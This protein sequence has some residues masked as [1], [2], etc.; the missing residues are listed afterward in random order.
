MKVRG[1]ALISLPLF[2]I[3]KFG[4]K[5]HVRWLCALEPET[6]QVF[7]RPINKSDWFP[8]KET[9]VEPTQKMREL[10]FKDHLQGAFECGRYSAEYGL[11]GI[12]KVLVKMSSPD[13]L[14]NRAGKVL[15]NYY[16][17]CEIE[18]FTHEKSS[19]TLRI[20]EFKDMSPCIEQRIAGWMH[21]PVEITGSGRVQVKISKSLTENDPFTEFHVSWQNSSRR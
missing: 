7:S 16:K 12:Y 21:R 6:R 20:T 3:K 17:P 11:K 15:N 13:I 14:I 10:F 4:S 5:E 18:V 19:A 1:E 9:L 2:I 8:L